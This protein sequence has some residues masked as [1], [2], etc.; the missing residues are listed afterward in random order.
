MDAS[1]TPNTSTAPSLHSMASATTLVPDQTKPTNEKAE[2]DNGERDSVEEDNTDKYSAERDVPRYL[3][4]KK[5]GTPN[6]D[7]QP[8][9]KTK[10]DKLMSKFQSPAVRRTNAAREREKLEEE[11]TGVRVYT[12]A[13]AVAGS[14]QATAAYF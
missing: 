11:R 8:K 12:P 4:Y 10:L 14:Y 1:T 9:P 13:G 3:Y 5:T 6:P 7:A 2:K